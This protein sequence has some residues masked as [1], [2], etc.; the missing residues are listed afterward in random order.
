MCRPGFGVGDV[1]ADPKADL[2]GY[3]FR[4]IFLDH[5]AIATASTWTLLVKPPNRLSVGFTA[6]AVQ[7][8]GLQDASGLTLPTLTAAM[9]I[10]VANRL[11][12]E[13]QET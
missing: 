8:E 7:T 11:R 13:R 9:A 2:A 3:R 1:L 5:S 4:Q 12:V 6:V 10:E